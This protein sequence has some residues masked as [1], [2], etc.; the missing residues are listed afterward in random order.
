MVLMEAMAHSV[1]VV[2]T[3]VMGVPELVEDG[4]SGLLVPAG[5]V[6]LLVDALARLVRDPELRERL[7]A[8]G[9]EKVL[10]EFDVNE[11]A[12]QLRAVLIERLGR[13]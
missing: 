8:N 13:P 4:H 10:A 5:R 7:G 2:T 6:D 12:R 11:S 1:P 9:R 3:Q